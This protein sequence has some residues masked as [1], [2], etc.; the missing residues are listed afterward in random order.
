L[1]KT[2]A[3]D[4]HRYKGSG[5]RWIPHIKKH[6]YDVTTEIL[7]ECKTNEEVKYWGKYYSKLWDVVNDPTWANLKPEEGEGGFTRKP[8]YDSEYRMKM[9]IILSKAQAKVDTVAK[10]S[11]IK[12]TLSDPEVKGKHQTACKAAQNR[13]EVK[14]AN[15]E[16]QL[17]LWRDE[18]V[19]STRIASMKSGS[20]HPGYDHQIYRFK[21][22][23][24]LIECCARQDLIKKYTLHSGAMAFLIAG[25][26]KSHAGWSLA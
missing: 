4:P 13:P 23:S 18:Q 2:A 20:D 3:K 14:L 10:S 7:K 25:K 5:K 8:W 24:G 12:K 1:G 19:R 22:K 9:H 17:E 26:V 6:G 16:K 21:H 15:K 11:A